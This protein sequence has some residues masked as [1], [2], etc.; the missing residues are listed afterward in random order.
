MAQSNGDRPTTKPRISRTLRPER[1]T[2]SD[3]FQHLGPDYFSSE[4]DEGLPATQEAR[5]LEDEDDFDVQSQLRFDR[6]AARD[7]RQQREQS[8]VVVGTK[9]RAPRT[10][11]TASTTSRTP[12]VKSHEGSTRSLEP[13]AVYG[14]K[15]ST[16]TPSDRTQKRFAHRLGPRE[17]VLDVEDND[18]GEDDWDSLP[19]VQLKQAIKKQ[20]AAP[21]KV[22]SVAKES[23]DL[24]SAVQEKAGDHQGLYTHL[25]L[26][27]I[28][29]LSI[30]NRKS[31]QRLVDTT[32]RA[33]KTG[34]EQ[35]RGFL[36]LCHAQR[37]IWALEDCPNT[38]ATNTEP[39]DAKTGLPI[40]GPNDYERIRPFRK[41]AGANDFDRVPI[42][43]L[44]PRSGRIET[45]SLLFEQR[46]TSAEPDQP[47]EP[48]RPL[49]PLPRRRAEANPS[50]RDA[51]P[52]AGASKKKAHRS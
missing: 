19:L 50:E 16:Y 5:Q 9:R 40:Y 8:V 2:L 18:T 17:A 24:A 22:P 38:R 42:W 52:R 13:A 44:K 14:A 21:I 32:I 4:S 37:H 48:R 46:V 45:T 1:S 34:T 43:R 25:G 35:E 31:L 41:A 23:V 27:A 20:R 39:L 15:S 6:N 28:G 26:P 36:A 10:S 12:R 7:A 33:N 11:R 30:A 51:A 47:V 29:P 3:D 49:N